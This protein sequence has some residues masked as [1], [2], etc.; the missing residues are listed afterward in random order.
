MTPADIISTTQS[1]PEV[2]NPTDETPAG[3]PPA[4]AQ[5]HASHPDQPA[6]VE[7]ESVPNLGW[8]ASV[9]DRPIGI[10]G[11]SEVVVVEWDGAGSRVLLV[12]ASAGRAARLYRPLSDD[13][14]F[15]PTY[16]DG[17]LVEGLEGLRNLCVLPNGRESRFDLVG[18]W[19]TDLVLLENSGTADAPSFE[20][21]RKVLTSLAELGLTHT[22]VAQM[23][24]VDWDGDDK[25]DL[26][27]GLNQVEDYWPEGTTLP[28]E[29]QV[30][31][32]QSGG[33]PCYNRA[34][35]W[36]GRAPEGRIRWLK[37]MGE[38]GDPRFI[39]ESELA[40][41]SGN[42]DLSLHPAPLAVS[43][44]GGDSLELLVSDDRGLV[45]IHRNF[46]GQRPP[47]L[48]DPR[49]IKLGHT[50]LLLP[51]DRTTV[52][53]AD[54][55]GDRRPEL[56]CGSADGRVF[57]VRS[58]SRDTATGP[59]ELR[60][61]PGPLWLGGHTVMTAG[62]LDG[63]GGLD[64][65]FGDAPGHLWLLKDV[66]Q[67][68]AHRYEAPVP[69]EAG[70]ARFR[71]DPGPDGRLGGPLDRRLGHACPV[72]ADWTGNGR[73]D[74]L[75]SGSGGDVLF[76]KNDGSATQP[77]FASPVAIRLGNAP[78]I[79]PPRVKVAVTDWLGNGQPS[80]VA[81]DLQG[82]LSLYPILDPKTV[83]TPIPLVDR[84]GRTIRL[85]GGYGLG[86]RCSIWAGPWTGSGQVD[87]LVGLP[88]DSAQFL[89][90]SLTGRAW[91]EAGAWPTVLLL[92][93]Q[94]AKGLVAR[95][96]TTIE[97]EPLVIGIDGCSPVGL[98][99]LDGDGLDLLVAADDGHLHHY[100]REHLRW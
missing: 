4:E 19:D 44:H 43:W 42:L 20:G 75:V 48:M 85:D 62:D 37:N 89:L 92:E 53:A 5:A 18:L 11:D 86:G 50:P 79:L 30:G 93:N 1:E 95:P 84:L 76:L 56:L 66:G 64:L 97:G 99:G 39:L 38:V 49:T 14:T 40:G 61:K 16:D 7:P 96:I 31:F 65:I 9:Q 10:G 74:L 36:R 3:G 21:E 25:V 87:L 91:S 17:T 27:L 2:T 22:Q 6:R 57:A 45:K 83:D 13:V 52:I 71:I 46:G 81:L 55:N 24:S 12:I 34:G 98:P 41:E 32:N 69:I 51:E 88:S 60:Q 54:M 26:L 82:F 70:G 68:H 8:A 47:V 78:L 90:P 28:V 80:L 29:Q 33:H 73:S 59:V 63:D 100:S 23:T 77:R 15:P 35:L 94:G 72:L 58:L 67:G